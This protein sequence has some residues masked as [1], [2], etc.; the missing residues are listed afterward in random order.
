MIQ[1]QKRTPQPYGHKL[2]VMA[3]GFELFW[4]FHFEMGLHGAQLPDGFYHLPPNPQQGSPDGTYC[5]TKKLSI[6]F[7]LWLRCFRREGLAPLNKPR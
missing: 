7:Q 3:Y 2:G 5:S 6:R 1:L 4:V